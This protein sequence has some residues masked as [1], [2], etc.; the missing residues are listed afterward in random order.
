MVIDFGRVSVKMA[1]L[2]PSATGFA[3]LAYDVRDIS[4]PQAFGKEA[5]EFIRS[6]M[7]RYFLSGNEATLT[8]SDPEAVF[9]KHLSLPHMVRAEMQEAIKL[10]MKL[11]LPFT[12]EESIFDYQ[13]VREYTDAEQVRKVNVVSIFSKRSM[14]E[15][16]ISLA[17][18]NNLLVV[19][20]SSAPFDYAAILH[21]FK[22]NQSV[23]AILDAGTRHTFLALY[24][25]ARLIFI[26]QLGFS[27]LKL[28]L[29]LCGTVTADECKIEISPEKADTILKTMGIPHNSSAVGEGL[30]SPQCVISL[31]QPTLENLVKELKRSFDYA[32][33][34]PGAGAPDICYLTGNSSTLKNFSLYLQEEFKL[35]M[36]SLPI[37]SC[38]DVSKIDGEKLAQDRQEITGFLGAILGGPINLLPQELR[39]HKLEPL[40]RLLVRVAG[41][42]IGVILLSSFIFLE[43]EV[44]N[45]NKRLKIARQHSQVIQ[46]INALKQTIDSQE[47]LE[48]T[49]LKN[50]A[51]VSAL[52]K[53]ISM[54]I[55]QNMLLNEMTFDQQSHLLIM[56]GTVLV[57]EEV[58]E[59]VV[60]DFIKKIEASKFFSEATL[61]SFQKSAVGNEFEIKCSVRR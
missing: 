11:E 1:C 39:V 5:S 14:I 33:S 51:P 58:S 61:V 24:K 10:Q 13:V 28:K 55:P 26:R 45:Y 19:K 44:R 31:M 42:L 36:A 27:F 29:S 30:V 7:A 57:G 40:A 46:E 41:V 8:I 35:A 59:N 49:V 12:P 22:S 23:T 34:G 56:R 47:K 17:K 60:V 37:P 50:E 53:L 4:L 38:I 9:I 6:F 15:K 20:I 2:E 32:A 3:L 16:F 25:N 18:E 43:L 54:L 52:L 48:W 21:Q